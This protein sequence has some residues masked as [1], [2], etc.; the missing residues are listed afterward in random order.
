MSIEIFSKYTTISRKFVFSEL[1][2]FMLLLIILWFYLGASCNRIDD[3]NLSL[4]GP[5]FDDFPSG[6]GKQNSLSNFN[7]VND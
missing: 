4:V 5:H 6:A 1:D 7:L 2:L 3:D